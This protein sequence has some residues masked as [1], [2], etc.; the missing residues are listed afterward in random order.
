MVTSQCMLTILP[1]LLV[2]M[3]LLLYHN[4]LQQDLE[5][6]M[7]WLHQNKLFLNTD[8]TKLMLVYNKV[9]DV[10]FFVTLNGRQLENIDCMK[11]LGV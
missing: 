10:A 8:K 1:C 7:L 9:Q 3:M 2:V 5:A 11:C 4:K 6:I